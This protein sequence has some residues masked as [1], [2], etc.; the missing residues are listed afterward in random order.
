MLVVR[1]ALVVAA[2]PVV[3]GGR[4]ATPALYAEAI[5]RNQAVVV[6]PTIVGF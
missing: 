6:L 3:V 4:K 2:G 1:A 5:A